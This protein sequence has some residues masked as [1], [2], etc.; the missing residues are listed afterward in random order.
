[1]DSSDPEAAI[2]FLRRAAAHKAVTPAVCDML[3]EVEL[4]LGNAPEACEA[5]IRAIELAGA[6]DEPSQADRWLNIAQLQEGEESRQ[7]YLQGIALLQ[8]RPGAAHAAAGKP[9]EDSVQAKLCTAFSAVA[10]LYLTDLCFEEGAEQ[11]CQAALD[12]AMRVNVLDSHEPIQGLA[13]LRLSQANYEEASQLMH[14][15]YRRISASA[16]PVESETRVAAS[17]MLL[18]CA[19]HTANCAE[20]ALDL[21]ANLMRE[22]DENVEIWFLMGEFYI[23]V[24]VLF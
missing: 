19:P 5:W 4:S 3:A 6:P 23:L 1:M 16:S 13:S 14:A 2:L 17:R 21:L 11:A 24:C 8:A 22:D 18:E 10:E 9:A 15:A 12:Q 20:A 7:S